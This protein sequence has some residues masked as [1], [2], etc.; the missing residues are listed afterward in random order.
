M[1]SRVET[2]A[3]LL[4]LIQDQCFQIRKNQFYLYL[5][6]PVDIRFVR[7]SV[8][9]GGRVGTHDKPMALPPKPEV[10]IAIGTTTNVRP[11]HRHLSPVVQS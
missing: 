6:R 3:E 7:F 9:D 5:Y 8:Y 10:E 1:Q 4:H 2:D 11:A